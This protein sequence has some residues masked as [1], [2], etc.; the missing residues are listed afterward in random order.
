MKISSIKPASIN[1]KMKNIKMA[2]NIIALFK[3]NII[4]TCSLTLRTC[5]CTN[6]LILQ[7]NPHCYQIQRTSTKCTADNWAKSKLRMSNFH[8]HVYS[9]HYY[10]YRTIVMPGRMTGLQHCKSL[11]SGGP[12]CWSQ[13]RTNSPFFIYSFFTDSWIKLTQNYSLIII[14]MRV[15]QNKH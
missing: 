11:F 9:F 10:A 3:N 1:V 12:C 6:K 2:E 4:I 14:G 15:A 5:Y 13:N 7:T 8:Y